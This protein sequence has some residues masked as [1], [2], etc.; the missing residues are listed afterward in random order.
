M[1]Y[2]DKMNIKDS[3]PVI[4]KLNFT[5]GNINRLKQGHLL[6][7]SLIQNSKKVSF[8]QVITLIEQCEHLY[9]YL[10]RSKVLYSVKPSKL[11]V[12][13]QKLEPSD[14][15]DAYLFDITYKWLI[16]FTHEDVILRVEVAG[17]DSACE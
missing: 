4:S 17:S 16:A 9:F 5:Y 15:I 1:V 14:E 12:Y 10:E 11:I 13:L 8:E 7:N 2:L 3:L 6:W